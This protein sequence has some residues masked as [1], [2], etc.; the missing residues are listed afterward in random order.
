MSEC[1]RACAQVGAIVGAPPDARLRYRNRIDYS[2]GVT[3][4][5][6]SR[7]FGHVLLYHVPGSG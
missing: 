6:V 7:P 1:A 5:E 3:S 4:P 2:F